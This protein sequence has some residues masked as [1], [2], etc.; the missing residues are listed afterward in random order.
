MVCLFLPTFCPLTGQRS[1]T[2]VLL[3]IDNFLFNDY[4]F[5]PDRFSKPVR[6]GF[7]YQ[8]S[9]PDGTI[10]AREEKKKNASFHFAGF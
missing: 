7:F 8:H 2:I 9:V 3:T 4:R 5:K 1:L 10:E 6:L